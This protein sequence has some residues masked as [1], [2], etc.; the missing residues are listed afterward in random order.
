MRCT[1]LV[2]AAAEATEESTGELPMPAVRLRPDRRWRLFAM[3]LIVTWAFRS[4]GNRH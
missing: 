4:V 1:L 3:L 2:G